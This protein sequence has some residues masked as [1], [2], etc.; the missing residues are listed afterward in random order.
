MTL[1]NGCFSGKE[2]FLIFDFLLTNIDLFRMAVVFVGDENVPCL[3]TLRCC[4]DIL[5]QQ[6]R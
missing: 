3:A 2:C 4:M 1:F 6:E 5:L